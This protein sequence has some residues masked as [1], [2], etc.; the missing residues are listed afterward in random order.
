MSIKMQVKSVIH[1]IDYYFNVVR[2]RQKFGKSDLERKLKTMNIVPI[3]EVQ[4]QRIKRF[5]HKYPIKVDY[6]WFDVYNTL[7]PEAINLE[8]YMPHDIYYSYVDPFF[9]NVSKAKAYDD[10]NMY[11]IYFHDVAQPRTIVR[12]NNGIYTDFDYQLVSFEHA[13][14]V[15]RQYE[16]LIIKP[17]VEAEG[18]AGIEFWDADRDS[19]SV[20]EEKL[21]RD[22]CY[23]V[24]E[25]VKQHSELN[26]IHSSSVNTIRI[27]TLL[28]DNEVHILSS[29]LRMGVNGARVDNASAGGIFCGIR[30]DGQLSP[31]AYDVNG[32]VYDKHP[33]GGQ[34]S[35]FKIP[36]YDLCCQT[37]IR[38]APRLSNVTR[39]CSWDLAIGEEGYPILI[40]ANLTYGGINL[41][42][43][44]N[45]PI[46]GG[47][48]PK[49]LD[50]VFK[51]QG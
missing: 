3:N 25:V 8:Y 49:I 24:S 29:I 39:L 46:L 38:L 34:L 9:S 28:I 33:Q 22:G 50:I 21:K 20:L 16:K 37:V 14:D 47:L 18:G 13:I 35:K 31:N 12:I 2:R 26:K 44:C 6:R 43:L 41:H 32:N 27:I 17:S 5:W 40:E 30:V 51:N 11:D 48:T 23:I 1:H 36:G 4:K 42:Q 19:I 7:D 45:G 15:C 10:K